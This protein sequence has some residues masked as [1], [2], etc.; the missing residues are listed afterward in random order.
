MSGTSGTEDYL[1]EGETGARWLGRA[2][3][4]YGLSGGLG[5]GQMTAMLNGVDPSRLGEVR[6]GTGA[7]AMP[8]VVATPLRLLAGW[9]FSI[10]PDKT[11]SALWATADARTGDMLLAIHRE[12]CAAMVGVLDSAAYVRR[13]AG[14]TRWQH[15]PGVL[16]AAVTHTTSRTGDP[17]LH[18]HFLIANLAQAPDGKWLTV[19]GQ[20]IYDMMQFAVTIY[21]RTLR[22]LATQRLGLTWTRPDDNG[23]RHI[24]GVPEK[25]TD[26]WA[27]R[28]KQIKDF[29]DDHPEISNDL[30]SA[31]TRPDKDDRETYADKITRWR[32]KALEVVPEFAQRVIGGGFAPGRS[33]A[34]TDSNQGRIPQRRRRVLLERA[35][36]EITRRVAVWDR[37]EALQTFAEIVPDNCPIQQIEALADELMESEL[38]VDLGIPAGGGLGTNRPCGNRYATTE[39]IAFEDAI[40]EFFASG[41]GQVVRLATD[42]AL[43]RRWRFGDSAVALD[44]EQVAAACGIAGGGQAHVLS[45]PAGTGKTSTLQAVARLAHLRG[46]RIEAL[47]PAQAAAD[48]LGEHVGVQGVNVTR[49]LDD[50][51]RF[52]AHTWCIVDEASMLPTHHLHQLTQRVRASGGKLILVGDP[53]QLSAVKGPEGMFRALANSGDVACHQLD[54]VRRFSTEWEQHASKQLRDGDES[55]LDTYAEHGRIRG[56]SDLSEWQR[57]KRV[58]AAITAVAAAAVERIDQ[59]DDVVV[60]AGSNIVA[61]ALNTAI[62][63]MLFPDRD[64]RALVVGDSR[65]EVGVGDRIVTRINDFKIRS[66]S[67]IP[68]INGWAWT[69]ES[70]EDNGDLK[71]TAVGRGG[72]VIL[73]VDYIVQQGSIQLGWASTVHTAQGRTADVGITVVDDGTDLELLYVGATRGRHTNLIFGLGTDAEVLDAAKAATRKVRAKL[74]AT[75]VKETAAHDGG[76]T[77]LRHPPRRD[78][79]AARARPVDPLQQQPQPGRGPPATDRPAETLSPPVA[80][81]T[82]PSGPVQPPEPPRRSGPRLSEL[83]DFEH[84]RDRDRRNAEDEQPAMRPRNEEPTGKPSQPRAEPPK[85]PQGPDHAAEPTTIT[86]R[87]AAAGRTQEPPEPQ[88][89]PRTVQ[90]LAWRAHHELGLTLDEIE[91]ALRNTRGDLQDPTTVGLLWKTLVIGHEAQIQRRNQPWFI[92]P[93][94]PEPEGPELS[95][96]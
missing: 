79:R 29:M 86:P 89:D 12:A 38:V 82:R 42:E 75:E 18:D 81:R 32:D 65:L 91:V 58:V 63:R 49:R 55:V 62:Q 33:G 85:L 7:R 87:F 95:G 83:I 22:H 5:E 16:C 67:N 93:T 15:A 48:L 96:P 26:L 47:A 37:V 23:H 92:A 45:G 36:A 72:N 28:S 52:D 30:A 13:G 69:V 74:S 56:T 64:T 39:L 31:I 68:I 77:P 50:Q 17:Q 20:L 11:F 9:E 54:E 80:S 61:A 43:C 25:L 73:P 44:G 2:A 84:P 53:H 14:G 78:H 70:I 59:G 3:A 94:D 66:T 24:A 71:L 6:D 60:T 76:D 34:D 8:P 51:R 41:A 46:A 90:E 40:S 27:E 57:D 10:G 1:A 88:T 4:V 21:G 19:D 35:A